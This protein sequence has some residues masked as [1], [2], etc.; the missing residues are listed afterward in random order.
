MHES[1]SWQFHLKSPFPPGSFDLLCAARR[2]AKNAQESSV[3]FAGCPLSG[4][5]GKGFSEQSG[6]DIKAAWYYGVAP[7]VICK[8]PDL[9]DACFAVLT[10]EVRGLGSVQKLLHRSKF[11]YALVSSTEELERNADSIRD[12]L[13][14]KEQQGIAPHVMQGLFAEPLR[15]YFGDEIVD[16][17]EFSS[18]LEEVAVSSIIE[19]P[20]W[21]KDEY[22][23]WRARKRPKE[24]DMRIDDEMHI[25]W[26]VDHG[27]K[28]RF[29]F[30]STREGPG[31]L[32]SLAIEFDGPHHDSNR[33]TR[34]NDRL[35]DRI[36]REA[37]LPLLRVGITSV[38]PQPSDSKNGD[39]VTFRKTF[40]E[41]ASEFVWYTAAAWAQATRR[42]DG[43]SVDAMEAET[44]RVKHLHRMN[45]TI[46]DVH[47]G[48]VTSSSLEEEFYEVSGRRPDITVERDDANGIRASMKQD[49]L[50]L[51]S[52][53]LQIRGGVPRPLVD[54][55]ELVEVYCR[56]HVTQLAL[57][58]L[59]A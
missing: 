32:P 47:R 54:W 8:G 25:E 13:H 7:L 20:D 26:M 49:G 29:D 23:I 16:Y 2:I 36:C 53:W 3:V 43:S 1:H 48:L 22:L 5:I 40:A 31:L 14:G 57:Q 4:F 55:D 12:A 10:P 11:P 56:R 24:E 52:P 30:L 19:L 35:K 6:K 21:S 50:T 15:K 45:P 59:K 18:L 42:I 27:N 28:T 41:F 34:F 51:Q 38:I 33:V 44:A 46:A 58:K 17:A 9:P 39:D 37:G